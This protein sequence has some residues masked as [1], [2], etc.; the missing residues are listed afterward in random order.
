MTTTKPT[1]DLH[2]L[3]D[4]FPLMEG[5]EF[6]ALVEDIKANGL[7]EPI[8]LYEDK[9]LD[10]RNRYRAVVK[11]ELQ[12][13]LKEENFRPYTGSDPLGFVVSANLHRRHLNESQRAAI[14][15]KLVTTTFGSNQYN[16]ATVGNKQAAIMLGVSEATVKMAK[17]VAKNAAPEIS[18][19]V[20]KGELRLGA[21]KQLLKVDKSQQVAELEK[22]KA[23][24]QK[25]KEEKKRSAGTTKG[26]GS[27]KKETKTNQAMKD[28]DDFCKK[29]KAFDTNQRRAFVNIF[30]DELAAL[31]DAI[32]QQE[33]MIGAAA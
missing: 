17:E 8:T 20:Q 22:I 33:A 4:I 27:P 3:A 18:Q 14:A 12:Y 10:G 24:K 9:I 2:P 25:E 31:L 16:R 19:L 30:K 21:A 5:D 29:W 15:A 13:R 26:N 28:V 6:A 11:A 32:Q 1:R 23:E 7:R